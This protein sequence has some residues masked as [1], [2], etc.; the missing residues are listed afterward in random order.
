[1][2]TAHTKHLVRITTLLLIAAGCFIGWRLLRNDNAPMPTP[3]GATSTAPDPAKPKPAVE[4]RSTEIIRPTEWHGLP[5]ESASGSSPAESAPTTSPS[6]NTQRLKNHI[7]FVADIANVPRRQIEAILDTAQ[8]IDFFE[9]VVSMEWGVNAALDREK[10]DAG[11]AI[12]KKRESLGRFEEWN[13]KDAHDLRPLT[14]E[15][16]YTVSTGG[17]HPSTHI[18]RIYRGEEPAFDRMLDEHEEKR[19]DMALRLRQLLNDVRY[20]K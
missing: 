6:V 9:G 8:K 18:F 7:R 20:L 14:G 19:R 15:Q 10:S 16:V 12:A 11:D 17:Q 13:G 3:R 5:V 1:M 2:T 4:T